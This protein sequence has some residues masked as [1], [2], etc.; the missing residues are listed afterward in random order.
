MTPLERI[1]NFVQAAVARGT[2]DLKAAH[3]NFD[4]TGTSDEWAEGN[5][6]GFKNASDIILH[7]VRET[8]TDVMGVI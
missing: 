3:E 8:M 7:Y 6:N 4:R 1:E 5:A 2:I